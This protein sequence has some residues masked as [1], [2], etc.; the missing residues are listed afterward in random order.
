MQ[1]K[2]LNNT[3]LAIYN[4]SAKET[5]KRKDIH[6]HIDVHLWQMYSQHYTVGEMKFSLK[7][8]CIDLYLCM[9]V[10]VEAHATY[11]CVGQRITCEH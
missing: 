1:Q 11:V 8:Y 10:C 3:L 6:G 7:F 2:A 9:Y 4:T 5:R